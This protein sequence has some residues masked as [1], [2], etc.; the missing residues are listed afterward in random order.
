MSFP[1]F[2]LLAALA[3]MGGCDALVHRAGLESPD[4]KLARQAPDAKAVGAACRES[5]RALED[6]YALHAKMQWSSIFEGWKDMD[7]YMRDNQ[8]PE[9]ASAP[10]LAAKAIESATPPD[11]V[12]SY[13]NQDKQPERKAP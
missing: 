5:R 13:T 8:I 6:C 10:A 7:G 1:R 9:R 11:P 3:L 2:L 4:Q 12:E